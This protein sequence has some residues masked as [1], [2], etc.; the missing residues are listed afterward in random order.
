MDNL[1]SL[2]D[3]LEICRT[4]WKVSGQS[5]GIPDSLDIWQ[6][7]WKVSGRFV[8]F[9]EGLESFVESLES[10]RTVLK[11][12][13][14]FGRFPTNLDGLEI[15]PIVGNIYPIPMYIYHIIYIL[16]PRASSPR[17]HRQPPTDIYPPIVG[18]IYPIP[19]YIQ[20]TYILKLLAVYI[21][22]QCIYIT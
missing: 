2:T 8:K 12:V 10:F 16:Q 9:L 7:V 5:G 1:E 14:Q 11:V 21:R 17:A 13:G 4:V 18:S 3:S 20:L 6:T 15:P 19:I 22:Y